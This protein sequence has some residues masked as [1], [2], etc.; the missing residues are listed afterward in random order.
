MGHEDRVCPCREASQSKFMVLLLINGK[1][2]L[3][4]IAS[5]QTRGEFNGDVWLGFDRFTCVPIQTRMVKESMLTKEEKQ[6]LKVRNP[7]V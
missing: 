2:T 3:I 7:P 5:L 6:W 1:K 4:Q